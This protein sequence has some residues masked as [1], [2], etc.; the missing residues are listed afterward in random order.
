MKIRNGFVSNSS[1]SSFVISKKDLTPKQINQILNYKTE[2]FK[3]LGNDFIKKEEYDSIKVGKFG[4]LDDRWTL[5]ETQ[6]EIFGETYLDNFDFHLYLG[7]IGV[8]HK[9]IRKGREID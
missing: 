3:L 1:S 7:E 4:W 8:Q 6:D 2:V 5:T 9:H